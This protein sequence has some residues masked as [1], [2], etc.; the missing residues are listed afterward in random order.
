MA[1]QTVADPRKLNASQVQRITRTARVGLR[2]TLTIAILMLMLPLADVGGQSDAKDQ[3][4]LKEP[5]TAR[6]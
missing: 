4:G 5:T 1:F 6:S 2:I 3:E